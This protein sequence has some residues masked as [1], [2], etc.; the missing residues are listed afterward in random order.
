MDVGVLPLYNASYQQQM[1]DEED[2]EWGMDSE[3]GGAAPGRDEDMYQEP[4]RGEVA[5]PP[6]VDT[7]DDLYAEELPV[8]RNVQ[9]LQ[10]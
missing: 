1:K 3:A 10:I 7:R 5:R 9:M 8:R 2:E 6:P 4:P